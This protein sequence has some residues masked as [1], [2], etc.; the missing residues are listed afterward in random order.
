MAK[1]GV[2]GALMTTLENTAY[3]L[4]SYFSGLLGE[5]TLAANVALFNL[6]MLI[7]RALYGVAAASGTLIGNSIGSM[8]VALAKYYLYVCMGLNVCLVTLFSVVMAL[9]NSQIALFYNGDSVVSS[10]IR[11]SMY[12]V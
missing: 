6:A 8:K 4:L 12:M 7:Y 3:Q 9:F 5:A 1:L 11:S 2:S 10:I